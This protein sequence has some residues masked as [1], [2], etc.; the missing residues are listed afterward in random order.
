MTEIGEIGAIHS[1][2]QRV[3]IAPTAQTVIGH[4]LIGNMMP[5]PLVSNISH[6]LPFIMFNLIQI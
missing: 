6:V 1:L 5:F 2:V 4:L 3:M